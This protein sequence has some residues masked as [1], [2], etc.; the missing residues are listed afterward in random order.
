[1]NFFIAEEKPKAH[2]SLHVCYIK[3]AKCFRYLARSSESQRICMG[4]PDSLTRV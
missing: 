2:Y 1:M 4:P 3:F